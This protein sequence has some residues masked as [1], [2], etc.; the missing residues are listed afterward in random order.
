MG[1]NMEGMAID[2]FVSLVRGTGGTSNIV[3][4]VEREKVYP[5]VL[6]TLH[7][8]AI[9]LPLTAKRQTAVT[10]SGVSGFKFG[11]MEFDLPLANLYPA[12]EKSSDSL[13][14]GE[15]AGIAVGAVLGAALLALL[16]FVCVMIAREK[17]GKPIFSNLVTAKVDAP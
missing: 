5:K 2:E 9:F 17:Q 16:A 13:S 1:K 12:P 15:M 11:F 8:E 4:P 14:D 10:N 7:D 3:D 6:T